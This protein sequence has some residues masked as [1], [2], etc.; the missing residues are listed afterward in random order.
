MYVCYIIRVLLFTKVDTLYAATVVSCKGIM[1]QRSSSDTG[2]GPTIPWCDIIMLEV[3]D[4]YTYTCT[5]I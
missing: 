5:I 2:K 4:T 1:L 3:I